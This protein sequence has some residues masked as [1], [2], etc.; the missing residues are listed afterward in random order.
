MYSGVS[1]ALSLRG[2][3]VPVLTTLLL[4]R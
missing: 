1:L 3:F 2:P 4:R